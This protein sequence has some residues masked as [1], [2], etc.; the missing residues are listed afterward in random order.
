MTIDLR[1]AFRETHGGGAVELVQS[2]NKLLVV[3]VKEPEPA[4]H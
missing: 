4:V 3:V 1:D 2:V